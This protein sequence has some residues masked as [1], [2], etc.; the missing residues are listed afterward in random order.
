MSNES[1]ISTETEQRVAVVT[2]AGGALGRSH[3]LHLAGRGMAVVVNDVTDPEPVVREVCAAGGRAVGVSAGVDTWKGGEQI[4]EKA[5]AEFGRLDVV[6]NNAGILRDKSFG[7]LTRE[8]V[9]SVLA[10]HL[11]GAFHVTKAA[12]PHLVER[13]GSVVMT[14]SGSGLYGNFGQANYGAAKMGLVGLTRVLA[15]EGVRAGV[16]VNAIAPLARSGMTEDVLPA[17]VL[18]RLD[19]VWVSPLVGWLADPA[20]ALNGQIWSVAGGRYARVAVVEGPGVVFDHVPTPEE[21]AAAE[22]L[23]QLEPWTEPGS[24]ADQVKL[25]SLDQ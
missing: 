17:E 14:S 21:L 16:R 7:K 10:V 19:P 5:L 22:G 24:L 13:G 18:E 25:L 12:W 20:C 6:V 8:M 15:L 2:G 11:H 23:S 1:P 9:E 3:A 4:V